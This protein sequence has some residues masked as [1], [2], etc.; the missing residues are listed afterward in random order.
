MNKM[1]KVMNELKKYHHISLCHK[2]S[3]WDLNKCINQVI[4]MNDQQFYMDFD[5]K[6]ALKW[7]RAIKMYGDMNHVLE[8]N[9]NIYGT[10]DP[11]TRVFT[12]YPPVFMWRNIII[13]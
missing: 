9:E 6:L 5:Y 2:R 10:Y 1:N 4:Y 11:L 12:L 8:F 13:N 3:L 7:N